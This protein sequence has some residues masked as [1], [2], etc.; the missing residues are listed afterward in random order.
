[1]MQSSPGLDSTAGRRRR[2][3]RGPFPLA[4]ASALLAATAGGLSCGGASEPPP[5]PSA[6]DGLVY[7][8]PREGGGA[9][10]AQVRISD[11]A[12]RLL[13]DSP[14]KLEENPHW[15]SSMQRVL[16]TER[17]ADD[18]IRAANLMLRDPETGTVFSASRLIEHREMGAVVSA[19]GRRVAYLFESPPGLMPPRGVKLLVPMATHDL[20][21][22]LPPPYGLFLFPDIAPDGSRVVAQVHYAKRGDD[23]WLLLPDVTSQSLVS[24]PRWNDLAPRFTRSGGS[25]F[26]SRSLVETPAQR[27]K[28]RREGAPEPL[29]GGDVCKVH[30]ETRRVDC[31]LASPDAHEHGVVPSPTRDEVVFLRQKDGATDLYL[32]STEGEDVRPLTHEPQRDERDPHWSP[33]GERVAFTAG[34]PESS[35]VVVVDR[36]GQV[37]LE[38]PGH[39]AD[40]APPL[41]D[42]AP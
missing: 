10:V 15:V 6:N 19:D 32:A 14:D 21:L 40:W 30:I 26:F 22:A 41:F 29:G 24:N 39:S 33:D 9:D 28:R 7:V 38:T 27:R 31:V 12:V 35:R 17:P 34:P 37:L 5:R 16:Y 2:G 23:I 1:M 8:L 25:V 4:L 42:A 3:G 11:G 13:T 20:T 36:T 18:P